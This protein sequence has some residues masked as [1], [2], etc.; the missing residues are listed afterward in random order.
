MTETKLKD[1]ITPEHFGIP[2]KFS[3]YANNYANW[4]NQELQSKKEIRTLY[5]CRGCGHLYDEKVSS[6]DCMENSAN[7]YNEWTASPTNLEET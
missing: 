5:E 7:E 2:A 4:L 1:V 6:C 3:D